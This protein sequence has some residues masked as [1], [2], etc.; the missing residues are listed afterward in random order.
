MNGGDTRGEAMLDASGVSKLTVS[1]AYLKG[2]LS[3][4]VD[5]DG[6]VESGR[7][8]SR[9]L[10]CAE[11]KIIWSPEIRTDR[12]WLVIFWVNV[13]LVGLIVA[14]F[15]AGEKVYCCT[16]R[17]VLWWKGCVGRRSGEELCLTVGRLLCDNPN[18]HSSSHHHDEP[19][20]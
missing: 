20:R 11:E 1:I 2:G 4:P 12:A 7:L 3:G 19:C 14:L 15:K 8:V 13:G 9:G 10:R 5:D 16:P 17:T 6:K 18:M